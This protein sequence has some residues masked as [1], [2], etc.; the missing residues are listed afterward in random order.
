MEG[1]T[2]M[3]NVSI[4]TLILGIAALAGLLASSGCNNQPPAAPINCEKG[5]HQVGDKCVLNQP[6][7]APAPAAAA[8]AAN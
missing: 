6:V 5:T 3:K 7:A 2:M 8:P 4:P 1:E